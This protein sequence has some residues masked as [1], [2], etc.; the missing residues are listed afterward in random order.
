MLA[1]MKIL[2]CIIIIYF[3]SACGKNYKHY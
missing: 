2:K 3:L 1:M